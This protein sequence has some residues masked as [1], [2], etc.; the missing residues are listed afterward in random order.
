MAD[1]DGPQGVID[2]TSAYWRL[3][4]GGTNINL[5]HLPNKVV[6]L[7]KRSLLVVRTQIDNGGAIIAANDSDIMQFARDT[8]S[9]MWPRDG[10]LVANALDLAGFPDVARWFYKFC[11]DVITDEGYFY[12]KY[13]PDGSPASSWHP[14]VLKGVQSMPIQ[15]DETALVVWALWR[16]YFRYRDIEYIR[17]SGSTSSRMRRLHGALRRQSYRPAL[18]PTTCGKSAGAFT[19]SPSRRVR[20]VEGGA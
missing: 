16:H 14:W 8:Y 17:P 12:H 10:A 11:S 2:R 4:V 1:Q 15:E 6:E 3:W 5:A 18:L 9:Y 7:L 19:R 13:N 20:R